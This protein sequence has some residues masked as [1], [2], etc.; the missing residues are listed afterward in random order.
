[1]KNGSVL[2]YANAQWVEYRDGAALLMK[3]KS[4]G[5]QAVTPEVVAVISVSSLERIDLEEPMTSQ[6]QSA[7]EYSSQAG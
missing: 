7:V 3:L 6:T 1:M 2:T 4:C 5:W